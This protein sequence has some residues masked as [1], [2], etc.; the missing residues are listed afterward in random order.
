MRDC[1]S[2]GSQLCVIVGL[3]AVN[4]VC[5]VSLWTIMCVMWVYGQSIMCVIVGL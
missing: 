3:W 2:M 5:D 4:Y 1:G